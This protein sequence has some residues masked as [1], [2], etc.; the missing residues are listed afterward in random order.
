MAG[1][2]IPGY[3]GGIGDIASNIMSWVAGGAKSVLD[4]MISTMNIKAPD[5]PG[6]ENIASGM[7]NKVKDWALD[8][9]GKILPKFMATAGGTA[10]TPVNVP[11]T[12]ADWIKQAMAL[13]S[14]P[15]NWLNDLET[16]VMHE[17]G[18]NP[19]AINLT[20]SNA[21]AGHPSQGLFQ[22]IPSTFAA[23]ALPGHGNILDP[24]SNSIAGIR[25]IKSRYGDVFHVPG[26]VS[27]SHGGAY[28]GYS[29]G[30]VISEPISGIGLNTGKRYSFG[31]KGP[32][33]VLP[34]VPNGV[35][36]A[37]SGGSNQSGWGS[38]NTATVIHIHN[39]IDG[40]EM[41]DVIGSR[42]VKSARTT[43]PIRSNA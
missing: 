38:A 15:A 14:T 20:D 5:L 4:G 17:S 8:W 37:A 27:M 16:I 36:V 35:N 12:V 39:Y 33:T 9:I 34:Y 29:E 30:G 18:G 7:F 6:M 11:G 42:L 19:N 13:T 41:T 1:G 28:Q 32:E 10:G 22:T 2:K 23:Y 21:Q 43:G 26:I 40:K 3:A 25:Y 24:I 31:E